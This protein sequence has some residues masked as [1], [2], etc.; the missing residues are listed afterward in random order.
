MLYWYILYVIYFFAT[1]I[2]FMSVFKLRKSQAFI[3][4]QFLACSYFRTCS[5][6]VLLENSN[7]FYN[8][9]RDFKLNTFY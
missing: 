8:I 5:R 6:R 1:T 4:I 3:Q 7:I 9:S 2:L